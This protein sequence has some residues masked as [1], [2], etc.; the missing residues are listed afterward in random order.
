[1]NETKSEALKRPQA[2]TAAERDGLL[3]Y[4]KAE[5]SLKAF[6]KAA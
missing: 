6:E 2:E 1:M 5:V 3:L 4:L